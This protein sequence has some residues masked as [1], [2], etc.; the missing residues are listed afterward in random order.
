[1][2]AK[3]T[4]RICR[5]WSCG[6]AHLRSPQCLR[7]DDLP[8]GQA[9]SGQ[10]GG[11]VRNPTV[12]AGGTV[13]AKGK[14]GVIRCED[15]IKQLRGSAINQG[16][17]EVIALLRWLYAIDEF[18]LGNVGRSFRQRTCGRNF[19]ASILTLR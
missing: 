19:A 7:D 12:G 8:G 3:A 16:R 14:P 13:E 11:A 9:D 5:V 4:T 15:M 2:S 18:P 1:M 10:G 6:R 17:C